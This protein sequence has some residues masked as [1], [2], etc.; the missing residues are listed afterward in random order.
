MFKS[1]MEDVIAC[2]SDICRIEVENGR[3]ILEYRGYN[4]HDLAKHSCNEE[5]A[6]LLLF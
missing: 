1:G 6:Y 2:Q 4:I 5:V 3:V